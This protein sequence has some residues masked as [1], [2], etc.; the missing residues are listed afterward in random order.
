MSEGNHIW[1]GPSMAEE[2]CDPDEIDAQQA[3][4]D[5]EDV[6]RLRPTICNICQEP[7]EDG[8]SCACA[9]EVSSLTHC[10]VCHSPLESHGDCSN[11]DCVTHQVSN[12]EL[13]G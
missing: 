6:I 4:D 5:E 8:L 12:E 13:L 7:Y 1:D 3:R 10:N 9:P 2:A 11:N